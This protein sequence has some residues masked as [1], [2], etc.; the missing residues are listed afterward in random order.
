MPSNRADERQY[1]I[2]CQQRT[3]GT[4]R[5]DVSGQQSEA[6]VTR[7]G[8]T[9]AADR[10]AAT[11]DALEVGVCA[12]RLSRSECAPCSVSLDAAERATGSA[13]L[14]HDGVLGCTLPVPQSQTT[15][16]TAQHDTQS[17][18]HAVCETSCEP[19]GL[20]CRPGRGRN[21]TCWC[22]R[23][24][25]RVPLRESA[26]QDSNQSRS[27][28]TGRTSEAQDSGEWSEWVDGTVLCSLRGVCDRWK[29]QR[30]GPGVNVQSRRNSG[31]WSGRVASHARCVV[32]PRLICTASVGHCSARLFAASFVLR[33]PP[34]RS[35]PHTRTHQRL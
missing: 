7:P 14:G 23:R 34:A 8:D 4:T 1:C 2:T 30:T 12:A 9:R 16:S 29:T 21:V 10:S 33:R 20:M 28:L 19:P 24:H 6:R 13:D 17:A 15:H 3:H 31:E 32:R 25:R 27:H 35:A 26:E 11:A 18:A 5:C 22:S